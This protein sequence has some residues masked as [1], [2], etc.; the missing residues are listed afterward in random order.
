[1]VLVCSHNYYPLVC[2]HRGE[3]NNVVLV[4]LRVI[5]LSVAA[6]GECNLM[7]N[8]WWWGCVG[9]FRSSWNTH[10]FPVTSWVFVTKLVLGC[11]VSSWL[12]V[13]LVSF[14]ASL[15]SLM[16]SCLLT[17]MFPTLGCCISPTCQLSSSFTQ[18]ILGLICS[19]AA[20]QYY[21]PTLWICIL[22]GFCYWLVLPWMFHFYAPIIKC[23]GYYASVASVSVN[24]W[25]PSIIG[26]TPVSIDPNFLS[27]LIGGDCSKVPFDDHLP[28][29]SKMAATP[30]IL[31]LVS[32]D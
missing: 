31:D 32:I 12:N 5:I 18:S 7:L 8:Q 10:T 16:F 13:L 26:Q 22:E 29:S 11:G 1:V 21:F 19:L 20:F 6:E 14:V 28:R 3:Y 9:L 15:R 27:W 4:R 24:I 2:S 25:F 30:A 23:R 17:I